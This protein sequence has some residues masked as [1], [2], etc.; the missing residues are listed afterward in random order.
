MTL[1]QR[2]KM[3]LKRMSKDMDVLL[4]AWHSSISQPSQLI[5]MNQQ[6]LFSFPAQFDGPGLLLLF[7]IDFQG[8]GKHKQNVKKW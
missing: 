6:A 5:I 8:H 7:P 2:G 1:A 3:S 4:S